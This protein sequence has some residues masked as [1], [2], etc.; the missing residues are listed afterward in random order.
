VGSLGDVAAFSFYPSKN[1]G[2]L[3]D[4][5][6]ICARTSD[7]A[8]RARSLRDLGQRRKG[9][10]E[11]VGWNERLS[12]LQAA[13]LRVKLPYLEGWNEDRRRTA[14]RY[15]DQLPGSAGQLSIRDQGVPV[16]HLFPVRVRDRDAVVGRLQDAGVGVGVHYSPALHEQPPL[17]R[18]RRTELPNCVSWAR[19]EVSLPIFPGLTEAEVTWVCEQ[20]ELALGGAGPRGGGR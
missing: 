11:F 7:V 20:L 3:G 5:G 1:L 8:E 10:H 9:Q 17:R 2:A 4:G 16:F 13:F 6:A 15:A 14:A 19:E 12:S 18:A